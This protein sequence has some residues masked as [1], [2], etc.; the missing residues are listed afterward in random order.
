MPISVIYILHDIGV[1]LFPETGVPI[2][3]TLVQLSPLCDLF[4]NYRVREIH[5]LQNIIWKCKLNVPR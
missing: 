1:S 2:H 5:L 4:H 3:F